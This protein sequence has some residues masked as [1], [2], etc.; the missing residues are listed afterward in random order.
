MDNI[1]GRT[2]SYGV[3]YFFGPL[4]GVVTVQHDWIV[5]LHNPNLPQL[6]E[7]FK[8]IAFKYDNNNKILT[9]GNEQY[10]EQYRKTSGCD[11]TWY[12]I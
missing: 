11:H 5:H 10:H 1:V 3:T 7:R 9:V 2:E 4:G 12:R 6:G 8:P